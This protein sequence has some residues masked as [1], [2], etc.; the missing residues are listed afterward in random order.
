MDVVKLD[1][2]TWVALAA[3]ELDGHRRHRRPTN[4]VEGKVCDLDRRWR[5]LGAGCVGAVFLVDDDGVVHIVHD[6]VGEG[7]VGHRCHGRRVHPCLDSDTV[8][9]AGNG[10]ILHYQPLHVP[11]P[12]VLP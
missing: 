6:H 12:T 10:A 9:G 2:L 11:F 3:Y 7:D 5:R 4:A 1:V 8:G